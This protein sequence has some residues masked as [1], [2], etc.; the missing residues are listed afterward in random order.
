MANSQVG[1]PLL[2]VDQFVSSHYN[3]SRTRYLAQFIEVDIAENLYITVRACALW[4]CVQAYNT[5]VRNGIQSQEI[6]GNASQTDHVGTATTSLNY[7]FIDIPEAF[8]VPSETNYILDS[9]SVFAFLESPILSAVVSKSVDAQVSYDKGGDIA[10]ALYQVTDWDYWIDQFALGLSN[11]IRKTGNVTEENDMYPGYPG[12]VY[13]YVEFV[14]VRWVW[15]ALPG[16]LL[17]MSIVLLVAS[18]WQT[19]ARNAKPWKSK[20]LA[21]LMC[22]A[23]QEIQTA[24][25]AG[26]DVEIFFCY[27]K[28][29]LRLPLSCLYQTHINYTCVF[30]ESH[31]AIIKIFSISHSAFYISETYATLSENNISTGSVIIQWLNPLPLYIKERKRTKETI[32]STCKPK[33]QTI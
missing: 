10:M 15:L 31:I 23:D 29:C 21:L 16:T 5:S 17:T 20:A 24:F 30:G 26:Q 19:R 11:N 12:Y 13:F 9:W 32:Y 22:S 18:I 7:T 33:K 2:I 4:F 27:S 6:I 14:Q 1:S 25:R 8:G 3:D 28:H